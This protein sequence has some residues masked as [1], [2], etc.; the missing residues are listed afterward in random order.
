MMKKQEC[1]SIKGKYFPTI[2]KATTITA[3]VITVH[4]DP[5]TS[6]SG[7]YKSTETNIKLSKLVVTSA[8]IHKH[9][10]PI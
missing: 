9:F 4:I 5:S 6:M 3:L 8:C 10:N 2:V 7:I 1:H